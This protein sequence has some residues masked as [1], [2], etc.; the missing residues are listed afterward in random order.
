MVTAKWQSKLFHFG[1]F[2]NEWYWNEGMNTREIAEMC[3]CSSTAVRHHFYNCKIPLKS[4]AGENHV[5][6]NGV[7]KEIL[8]GELLGDGNLELGKEA[9]GSMYRHSNKHADYL[10]W[11]FSRLAQHGLNGNGN[12]YKG[13][14]KWVA[15]Q[16]QTYRYRELT[17]LKKKWYP[18]GI[19]IV[20]D[21]IELTPLVVLHWY[22]GDGCLTKRKDRNLYCLYLST[23]CFMYED[24]CGLNDNIHELGIN[25]YVQHMVKD[26]YCINIYEQKSIQMFLDYTG[27]CP[28]KIEPI[29]GYKFLP[30]WKQST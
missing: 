19:K 15:Y 4:R 12:I 6:I 2:L 18:N 24:V 16:A 20:P 26:Q 21:N 10:K 14:S 11:L 28:K 13:H 23:N 30:V 5:V 27:G 1:E 17:D 22:L 25:S 29:Y 9:K 3:G 7:L 8:E